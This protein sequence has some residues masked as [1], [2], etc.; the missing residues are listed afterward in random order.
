MLY[1]ESNL[2]HWFQVSWLLTVL[3]ASMSQEIDFFLT[4]K[5]QK[6]MQ[7]RLMPAT[8]GCA[9]CKMKGSFNAFL[10]LL[11]HR[12]TLSKFAVDLCLKCKDLSQVA[13]AAPLLLWPGRLLSVPQD[14]RQAVQGA[15][16]HSL[17]FQQLETLRKSSYAWLWKFK[18]QL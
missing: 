12:P 2:D 6:C 17:P 14:G 15:A 18:L 5:G 4:L 16:A 1:L 10:F 7:K 3:E 11:L 8:G 13:G 9:G